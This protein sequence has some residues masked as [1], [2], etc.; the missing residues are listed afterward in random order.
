MKNLGVFTGIAFCFALSGC[1]EATTGCAAGEEFELLW[2][3]D[4]D[5]DTINTER[6]ETATHTFDENLAVF[7][8]DN[9]QLSDGMMELSLG[10]SGNDSKPYWGGELRTLGTFTYGRF[11][12]RAKLAFAPGAISSFFTFY[13]EPDFSSNWQEIDFEVVGKST[14][15]QQVQVN[16]ISNSNGARRGQEF[17]LRN[18][19]YEPGADFHTYAF[20]WTPE[21]VTFFIDGDRVHRSTTDLTKKLT[22]GQKL[23]M[24]LWVAN[25][26]LTNTWADEPVAAETSA[27]VA[28]YDYVSVSRFCN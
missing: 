20:E 14:K 8:G 9:V 24:N 6:W 12:T 28:Q 3:D 25:A 22:D 17:L 27:A 5:G 13:D 7:R 2:Q 10:L 23:M 21:G 18:L 1:A 16:V 26:E 15:V 4:F 11:E 19:S